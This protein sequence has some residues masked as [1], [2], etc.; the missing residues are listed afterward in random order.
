M[1]WVDGAKEQASLAAAWSLRLL[2]NE[3]GEHAAGIGADYQN[4][5]GVNDVGLEV[6]RGGQGAAS[7]DLVGIVVGTVGIDGQRALRTD[8]GV[9]RDTGAAENSAIHDAGDVVGGATRQGILPD[10]I[11]HA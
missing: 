4:R 5:V 3:T 7:H 6:I 2:R 10:E 11:L 1:R 8:I 9:W